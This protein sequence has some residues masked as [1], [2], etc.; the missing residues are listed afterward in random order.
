MEALFENK[1]AATEPG[2]YG[3]FDLADDGYEF[4][5]EGTGALGRNT[6]WLLFGMQSRYFTYYL[7]LIDHKRAVIRPSAPSPNCASRTK[8]PPSTAH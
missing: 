5:A 2:A 3:E 8:L 7:C 4:E 6:V 1:V